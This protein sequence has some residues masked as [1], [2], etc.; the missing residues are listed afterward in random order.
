MN[1]L[2]L[3]AGWRSALF[4]CVHLDLLQLCG[5][6]THWQSCW[7]ALALLSLPVAWPYKLMIIVRARKGCTSDYME[8]ECYGELNMVKW[9]LMG[10][11]L[12]QNTLA[13]NVIWLTQSSCNLS[14]SVLP[15]VPGSNRV[16]E[17][18]T[19]LVRQRA[20]ATLQRS[21]SWA[22]IFACF[23]AI[24]KMCGAVYRTWGPFDN[25]LQRFGSHV[26]STARHRR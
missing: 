12:E 18:A 3:H 1:N 23:L 26:W 2:S 8:K 6:E 10:E 9:G 25:C 13:D 4:H 15:P 14:G 7:F 11:G 24:I 22:S 21:L 17:S 20:R 5:V 19:R 16:L